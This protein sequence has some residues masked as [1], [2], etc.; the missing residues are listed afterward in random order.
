M[1]RVLEENFWYHEISTNKPNKGG[2]NYA[3]SSVRAYDNCHYGNAWDLRG[4]CKDEFHI[5]GKQGRRQAETRKAKQT[6]QDSHAAG[7]WNLSY[8]NPRNSNAVGMVD[9]FS[10]VVFPVASA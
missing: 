9:Y 10:M 2:M 8:R 7:V 3:E 4:R 1:Q 6:D 5:G